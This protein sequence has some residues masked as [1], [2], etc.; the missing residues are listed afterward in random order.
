MFFRICLNIF[1]WDHEEKMVNFN[2]LRKK[3]VSLNVFDSKLREEILFLLYFY[4]C[5]LKINSEYQL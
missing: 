3:E 4:Y 5:M 2:I 1:S